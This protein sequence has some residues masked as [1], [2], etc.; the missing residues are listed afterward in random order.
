V[1]VA[2]RVLPGAAGLTASFGYE[3]P[4][5]AVTVPVGSSN[6]LTSPPPDRG[7]PTTLLAG[8]Q[9]GVF[10]AAIDPAIGTASRLLETDP[11]AAPRVATARATT[12][13]CLPNLRLA[14]QGPPTLTG[15]SW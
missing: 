13:R 11:A 6:I 5:D 3:N 1:P 10:A 2:E 4:G 12:P 9:R 8:R 7:Q 14:M 15:A